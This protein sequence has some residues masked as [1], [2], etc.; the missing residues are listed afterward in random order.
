MQTD[1]THRAE[2]SQPAQLT[3]RTASPPAAIAIRQRHRLRMLYAL[4]ALLLV[5]L[6]LAPNP[7]LAQSSTASNDNE[8]GVFKPSEEISEDFAVPFP[9][10]I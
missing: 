8:S 5:G 1:R 10:D 2:P 7:L 6:A 4:I 9:V 3:S